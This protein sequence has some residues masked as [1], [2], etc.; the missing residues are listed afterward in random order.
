M[1]KRLPINF[2]LLMAATICVDAVSMS[3]IYGGTRER[4]EALYVALVTGQLSALCAWASFSPRSLAR[5][6][7][8]FALAIAVAFWAG[9]AELISGKSFEQI[10][11]AY[12]GLWF[13]HVA[14]LLALLWAMKRTAY[15]RH[16]EPRADAAVWQFSMK[17]LLAM[18]TTFAVLMVVLRG[19]KI[20]QEVWL[21]VILL[22]VNNI[23]LALSCIL[24]H[25]THWHGA[26]RVA[27]TAGV[28]ALLGSL[29][30][31]VRG[32]PEMIAVNLIHAF[33]VIAW[34]Q[35]GGIMPQR[36]NANTSDLAGSN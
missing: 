14:L 24:I 17:H 8:A 22:I 25:G 31:L 9:L 29:L 21:W 10:V 30:Y 28:A 16:W 13:I 15:G 4:A 5:S 12:A 20:I 1:P 36:D 6:M 7:V 11:L 27:A 35:V 32:W 3:W 23:G 26:A 18:M 34:L 2:W 33:V 19:A